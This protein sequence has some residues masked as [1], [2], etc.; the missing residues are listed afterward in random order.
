MNDEKSNLFILDCAKFLD[1]L[2]TDTKDKN[3][4]AI[5]NLKCRR[6]S[7]NTIIFNFNNVLFLISKNRIAHRSRFESK[8][9]VDNRYQLH[10]IYKTFN[11]ITLNDQIEPWIKDLYITLEQLTNKGV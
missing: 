3:I 7:D 11:V 10:A 1:L 4:N 8:I 2:Y 5:K 9:R 6:T